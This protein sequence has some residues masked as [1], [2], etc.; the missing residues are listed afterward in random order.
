M[1][2]EGLG[3]TSKFSEYHPTVNLIYFVF[4]IGITMFATSPAFLAVTFFCAWFYSVLLRGYKAIKMN[5]VFMLPIFAVMV[6]VNTFFNHNG[7]T[8]LFYLNRAPIT[9]EAL[10]FGMAAAIV[11][12]SVIIW[13]MCFNVIMSADKFIFLFGRAA[14]ILGLLL[15]MTFRFIKLLKVRFREISEGQKCLGKEGNK[16]ILSRIR[17]LLKEVSIL[18]SWSLE[19][20]IETAD[21]MEARGYGLKG[22]TF[23]HIYKFTGRDLQM[24]ILILI[25][26]GI[27]AAGCIMKEMTMYYYPVL[28]FPEESWLTAVVLTFYG[29]LL[30]LPAISDIYGELKWERLNSEM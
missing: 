3:E 8:I 5:I 20:S 23:F 26:G 11:L 30:L 18:I 15:S 21:S 22:R 14:P 7:E 24:M 4:V 25:S 17:Q 27:S 1:F 13:F 10:V 16:R 9:K 19:A 28:D 6:F 12:T 2:K 29:I